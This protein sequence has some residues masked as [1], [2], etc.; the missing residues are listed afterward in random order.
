M[1]TAISEHGI[2]NREI[3]N[4]NETGFEI[5]SILVV[6]VIVGAHTC[7]KPHLI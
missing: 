4:F 1:K 5:D 2:L 6:N 7:G 3:Y